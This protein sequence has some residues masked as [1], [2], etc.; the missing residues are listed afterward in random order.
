MKSRISVLNIKAKYSGRFIY[1]LLKGMAM[2]CFIPATFLIS[3]FSV[4][5]ALQKKDAT[6]HF[7]I[8]VIFET[9]MGNDIDDALALDMLYKYAD[10]G[11]VKILAISNNKNSEY[12][13]QFI[14]VLN[15]WYGYPGIPL[16]TVKNGAN[17]EGDAKDYVRTVS[18]FMEDGK[19]VFKRSINDYAKV[20]ES[21]R[22]YRKILSQQPDNSVTIISVG[23]STN[24][25][26]RKRPRRRG[27]NWCGTITKPANSSGMPRT[28]RM[29]S[30]GRPISR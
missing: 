9:D 8:S 3:S 4:N 30:R 29:P 11:K 1:A 23:F 22:L 15:T 26:R 7:P 6:P 25:I 16:A 24:P 5:K 20:M 19:L 14:D 2:I 27:W 18:G 21:T 17:S 28:T 10:Q 13:I 12:S